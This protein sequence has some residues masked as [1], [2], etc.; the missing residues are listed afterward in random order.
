MDFKTYWRDYLSLHPN[1][2]DWPEEDL[3]NVRQVCLVLYNALNRQ[4][5][6]DDLKSDIES[7]K[8]EVNRLEREVSRAEEKLEEELQKNE[9]LNDAVLRISQIVE[10]VL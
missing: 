8:E 6:I 5:E 7:Y 9:D 1:I 10:N 3:E 4:E 2:W